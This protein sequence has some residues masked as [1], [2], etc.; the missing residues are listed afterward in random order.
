MEQT[1]ER[2][3]SLAPLIA[4]IAAVVMLGALA[5]GYC[6]LCS[7]VRDNGCLLPGTTAE[8]STGTIHVDMS[9]MLRDEAVNTM[10]GYMQAHLAGRRVTINYGDN[11]SISLSGTY[12]TVDPVSPIDYGMA[13]KAH[14]P[15][16]R[17]G[18]IWLGLIEQ[19]LKLSLAAA[20]L[21]PEG[22]AEAQR[23]AQFVE[24][25]VYVAPIGYICEVDRENGMVNVTHGTPG[26]RLDGDALYT[27]LKQALLDGQD[28]LKAE[29]IYIPTTTIDSQTIH[30][31]IYVAPADPYLLED[32]KLSLPVTGVSIH[33][34]EAQAILDAA[35]HGETCSIPLVYTPTDFSTCQDLLYQDVLAEN[36]SWMDGVHERSF[37]VNRTAEFCNE[38]VLMPGQ[39]FSYLG[40]IGDPAVSNGYM[41]S[42]GYQNGQTVEMEGGG[43][44]QVSSALYYCAFYSD[45]EIV[46]RANHA[47]T[48]SYV[49]KGLDA[50]VYYPSLDF[51]FR[52]NTLYPIK[53]IAY[54]E[55][56]DWGS[57]TVKILGTKQDGSYVEPEI[58]QLS[59]TPWEVKYK[60][61][62]TIARG[63]YKVSVTPYTGYTV[64]VHR[65]VY[66][67]NG[68]LISRTYENTSR[69]AKRDREVLFNPA[70][71]ERWGVNPDGTPLAIRTLTVNWVDDRG[72]VLAEPL[73]KTELKTG[74]A[75]STEQ[76]TF[77]GYTL[78]G[79]TGD[80]VSGV[81]TADRTV[82]YI[83]G[84]DVVPTLGD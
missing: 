78:K 62:E 27:S 22:E 46:W 74:S 20:T 75:Y 5:A 36:V 2:R 58:R 63:S 79:T 38:V 32:G 45:L 15:F 83:Y 81:M 18:A 64:E 33:V 73:I 19:P 7:W 39:I 44:C 30:D 43:A 11:Q 65:C 29:Y 84:V 34:E 71:A 82:T 76:K 72:N 50:T 1:K 6:G 67:E 25:A 60:P 4:L 59:M 17:L 12:L 42:T 66:D 28:S 54:T 61:D 24:D 57:V 10:S 48:V 37:N 51:Q 52:N 49:P 9:G 56:G 40:T 16:L 35:G 14:Q 53:L 13:Y 41:M 80:A 47:F 8:D 55:G 77:E 26:R 70:D 3:R 31:M 68:N 21:T 69:Y 23:I